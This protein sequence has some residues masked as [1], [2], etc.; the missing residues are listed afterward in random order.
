MSTLKL[1]RRAQ[2]RLQTHALSK[3]LSAVRPKVVGPILWR[4]VGRSSPWLD[5]QIK[6]I[7]VQLAQDRLHKCA[8]SIDILFICQIGYLLDPNPSPLPRL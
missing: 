4:P 8:E 1:G 7:L 2:P 5:E 6:Q 3:A